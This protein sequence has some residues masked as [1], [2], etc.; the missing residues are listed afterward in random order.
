MNAQARA[1]GNLHV[2][3][4]REGSSGPVKIVMPDGEILHGTYRVAND[5]VFGMAFSGGQTASA[6]AVGGGN[7]E[8]IAYG[9]KTEIMCRGYSSA[10]GQG[11]GQCQNE[12]GALWS[13]DW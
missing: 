5:G 8:M 9:P 12:D 10:F 6:L 11:S 2:Q 4:V 3:F 7:L 1:A 13:V